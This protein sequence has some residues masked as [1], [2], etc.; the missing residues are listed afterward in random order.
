MKNRSLLFFLLVLGLGTPVWSQRSS[1]ELFNG[2]REW[3]HE[4]GYSLGAVVGSYGAAPMV[5]HLSQGI[6]YTPRLIFPFKNSGSLDVVPHVGVGL[7][8][9]LLLGRSNLISTDVGASVHVN[10]GLG[11]T[12]SNTGSFGAFYGLG[13]QSYTI[14]VFDF[15]NPGNPVYQ[16]QTYVGPVADAGIRFF[17]YGSPVAL[18]IQY[19]PTIY[20]PASARNYGIQGMAS[21][22]LMYGLY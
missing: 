3:L 17:L 10:A 22:R 15:L 20:V 9:S 1:S 14:H 11:S 6:L 4:Y 7:T 16:P 19:A 21:A 8:S 2:E 13:F 5:Y 12:L 18:T